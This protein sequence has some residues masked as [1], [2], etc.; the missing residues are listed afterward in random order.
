MKKIKPLK[1]RK[2]KKYTDGKIVP[3]QSDTTDA[4]MQKYMAQ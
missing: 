1:N 3:G 4:L 2:L